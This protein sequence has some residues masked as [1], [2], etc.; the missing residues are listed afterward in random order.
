MNFETKRSYW[1]LMLSP[2]CLGECIQD[3]RKDKKIL[4]LGFKFRTYGGRFA[5]KINSAGQYL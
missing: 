1:Y 2:H 4:G 3:L 5:S